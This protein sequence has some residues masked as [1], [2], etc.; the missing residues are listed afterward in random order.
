MRTDYLILKLKAL[1][2]WYQMSDADK[3]L[4]ELTIKRLDEKRHYD[5]CGDCKYLSNVKIGYMYTCHNGMKNFR[6]N[7]AHYKY[8]HTKACKLFEKKDG[9]KQ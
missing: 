7:T 3:E 4:M 1:E 5:K 2:N 9:D 8:K 6:T